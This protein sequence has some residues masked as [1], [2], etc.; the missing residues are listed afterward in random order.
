M[1]L[2]EHPS[3]ILEVY[4]E[5]FGDPSDSKPEPEEREIVV[6]IEPLSSDAAER[7]QELFKAE[8]AFKNKLFTPAQIGTR[9][10]AECFL[11]ARL[12]ESGFA[13]AEIYAVMNSSPQSKWL[14][15][16]EEYRQG[17]I[18]AGIATAEASQREKEKKKKEKQHQEGPDLEISDREPATD[19][20]NAQRLIRLHRNNIKYC[21]TFKKW[22]V[23]DSHRWK[24]D[25]DG[26]VYRLCDD[27][28]REIYSEAA[29]CVDSKDRSEW[30]KFAIRS[31]SSH[32]YKDMLF[33]ASFNKEIAITADRL[34]VDP[35]LLNTKN[36]TVDL[37]T[38]EAREPRREDLIT[39]SIGARYD[40]TA[41]CPMWLKFLGEIFGGDQ[42]LI[43]YVQRTAGYTLTGSMVEQV[44][45]FCYGTGANGK[46]VFLAVLRALLG[47]Y[48]KQAS[49][50][51]FLIQ[52]TAKV[53]NDLAAL[54]GARIIT[55]SEAEEGSR[56]SMQVIK[57]WTGGDPI[58]ARFLFGE[59]FTF[60]PVGKIWLAANTK[61]V[62]SERNYAAWRRVHLIPF[63]VTIQPAAQDRALESKLLEELPGILIWAL[64]GLR[65]YHRIGLSPPEAV[66]AATDAYR[67]ENDSLAAFLSECC[68]IQKLAI[69]KNR[70]LFA[71]YLNFCGITGFSALSQTKFSLD[72]GNKPGI[73]STRDMYG[74]VWHGI[75][76]KLDW[77]LCR[78]EVG[79]NQQQA[80][81]S[82][83]DMKG[84]KANP[85]SFDNSLHESYFSEMP[86]YPTY[87][88]SD[89]DSEKANPTYPVEYLDEVLVCRRVKAAISAGITD[90]VKLAE[91]VGIPVCTLA[92][93]AG[94]YP[95]IDLQAAGSI[96]VQLN[97]ASW[98][99]PPS[100]IEGDLRRA[101]GERQA[102]AQHFKDV[103]E[104]HLPGRQGN[105]VTGEPAQVDTSEKIRIAARLEWGYNGSVDPAIVAG[106]LRLPVEEVTAWLATNYARLEK[107]DGLVRYTQHGAGEVKA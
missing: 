25:G 93:H 81:N 97:R 44:Y 41:K 66:I 58:T 68:E 51:T 27:V 100:Q 23:W 60:R 70:D 48:A 40:P 19:G 52:H 71:S 18:K 43:N 15:R 105:P 39:K 73:K 57:S 87:P 34:D 46:S 74:M 99:R 106:K 5:F 38:F 75:N 32:G 77:R 91:A 79:L 4:K 61:P 6:E 107:P 63:M 37:R 11:C 22:M 69:C 78:V 8:P 31:D 13:A 94:N 17:T 85:Q 1:N 82:M 72:L 59:D 21:H 80:A 35:W 95:G 3:E 67:R 84:M 103:A 49:F 16:D 28:I 26:S 45:F 98:W 30:A 55:A 29:V 9:S 24:I 10:T 56:L 2:E 14:E 102:R 92:R 96:L 89:T 65:E 36:A 86:T 20:G 76:L 88:A 90:P 104:K 64:D 50:D 53:R 33:L 47:D 62:I 101:E 12:W 83:K 42:D 54:A 7:L